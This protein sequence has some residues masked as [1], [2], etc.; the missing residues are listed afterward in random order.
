MFL[1][2]LVFCLFVIPILFL[3]KFTKSG[4]LAGYNLHKIDLECCDAFVDVLG[5]LRTHDKHTHLL[6]N[7]AYTGNSSASPVLNIF[8]VKWTNVKKVGEFSGF[9]EHAIAERL[10]DLDG[11][12]NTEIIYLE[13]TYWPSGKSHAYIIPIYSIAEYQDGRYVEANPSL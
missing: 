8:D 11:D 10:R 13:D 5:F 9:Y 7:Y 3:A 1:P 4:K 2:L 6:I 12:G